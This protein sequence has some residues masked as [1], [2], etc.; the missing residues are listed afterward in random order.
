[1]V[2]RTDIENLES[3]LLQEFEKVHEEIVKENNTTQ[4]INNTIAAWINPL[5]IKKYGWV[6]LLL[7]IIEFIISIICLVKIISISSI[8]E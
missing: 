8:L 1:M 6:I 5:F 4:S 2:E 3:R 7:I